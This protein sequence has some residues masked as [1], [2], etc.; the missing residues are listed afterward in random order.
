MLAPG[1]EILQAIVPAG[2]H[3][4]V[5]RAHQFDAGLAQCFF[6][7]LVPAVG[8]QARINAHTRAGIERTGQPRQMRRV[9][10]VKKLVEVLG[11]LLPHL[12]RVTPAEKG[13]RSNNLLVY[14][15]TVLIR[16]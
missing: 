16:R 8:V 10:Q 5:G 4:I 12:Y 6:S 7:V 13:V 2:I 9:D 15:F 14:T 1:S 3:H 11:N